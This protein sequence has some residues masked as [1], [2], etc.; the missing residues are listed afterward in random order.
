MYKVASDGR[1]RALHHGKLSD[2]VNGE[3]RLTAADQIQQ[4]RDGL[5]VLQ[6][7][8]NAATGEERRLLGIQ[9]YE[10]QTQL[11]A[12]KKSHGVVKKQRDSLGEYIAN[13]AR[14]ILTKSQFDLIYKRAVR[15]WDLARKLEQQD[16]PH[17][18]G[19]IA[20]SKQG[21]ATSG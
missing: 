1:Q 12:L 18:L 17:S 19:N 3:E 13:A 4:M 16:N 20:N 7:R 11:S 2:W 10:M 5:N 9:K 15:D 6:G 21:N 8:I 14:E